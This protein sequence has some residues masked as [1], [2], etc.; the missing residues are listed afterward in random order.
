[1]PTTR[2][3]LSNVCAPTRRGRR[4]RSPRPVPCGHSSEPS[5]GQDAAHRPED[6]SRTRENSPWRWTVDRLL[7]R[8]SIKPTAP[9][10]L[11]R[12][13]ARYSS[14]ANRSTLFPQCRL[15]D[16]Q[17]HALQGQAHE[18]NRHY[19]PPALFPH[20]SPGSDRAKPTASLKLSTDCSRPPNERPADIEGEN[21]HPGGLSLGDAFRHVGVAPGPD[22]THPTR[23]SPTPAKG[24]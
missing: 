8:F 23:T 9:L 21:R 4:P 11:S 12:T 16:A 6:R 14:T 24:V 1:M 10:G 15:G 19:D 22:P 17:T 20:S 7:V 2:S 13:A 18:A 5:R 3:A